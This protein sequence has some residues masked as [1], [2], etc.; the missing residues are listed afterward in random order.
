M[1][2][3]PFVRTAA[4]PGNYL[5][6]QAFCVRNQTSGWGTMATVNYHRRQAETL[7]RLAN[8]TSDPETAAAL[9]R[10]AAD[11]ARLADEA[12][13]PKGAPSE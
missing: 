10:L 5:A 6:S 13:K 11:H 3:N 4:Q 1:P 12:D 7:I 2:A 9:T 8:S